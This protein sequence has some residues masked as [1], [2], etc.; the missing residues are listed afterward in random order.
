MRFR[1]LVAQ[2]LLA[3]PVAYQMQQLGLE[4][5]MD[6]PENLVRNVMD[7]RPAGRIHLAVLPANAE[8]AVECFI[9]VGG[10]KTRHMHRI[11]HVVHRVFGWLDLRPQGAANVCRY[12]AVDA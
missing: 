10:K 6:A 3:H 1:S 4:R 11:G 2:L 7:A 8:M 9:P 5:L 12:F